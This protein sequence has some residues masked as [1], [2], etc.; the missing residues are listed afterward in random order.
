MYHAVNR[1]VAK[2]SLLLACKIEEQPRCAADILNVFHAS[3]LQRK[4]SK[5]TPL[6]QGEGEGEGERIY[7]GFS[8]CIYIPIHT[9]FLKLWRRNT[10]T[11]MF[12]PL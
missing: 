3:A 6:E 8:M 11:C 10:G 5:V 1:V 12:L 2:A 4:G 9:I 7:M